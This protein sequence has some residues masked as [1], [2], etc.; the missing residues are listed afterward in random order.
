MV[1]RISI[2]NHALGGTGLKVSLPTFD[3]DTATID[4]LAFDSDWNISQVVATGQYLIVNG[5][6]GQTVTTVFDGSYLGYTPYLEVF[7]NFEGA[8]DWQTMPFLFGKLLYWDAGVLK[9]CHVRPWGNDVYMRY[10]IYNRP[11]L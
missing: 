4:E 7:L 8:G 2:G 3:V 5:T 9:I 11:V 1:K 6:D 10:F